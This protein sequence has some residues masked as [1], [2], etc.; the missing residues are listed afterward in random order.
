M[1]TVKLIHIYKSEKLDEWLDEWLGC[2]EVEM[3]HVIMLGLVCWGRGEIFSFSTQRG[4][5][6]DR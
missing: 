1:E 4:G 5:G 6:G 3:R 2:R